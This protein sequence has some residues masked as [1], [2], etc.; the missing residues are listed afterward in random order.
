MAWKHEI[1]ITAVLMLKHPIEIVHCS[2]PNQG[3]ILLHLFG[4]KEFG[5]INLR[6]ITLL[7]WG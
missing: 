7:E 5:I 3:L 2:A 1:D 6:M 4:I